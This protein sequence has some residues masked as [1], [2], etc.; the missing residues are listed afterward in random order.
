MVRSVQM[1]DLWLDQPEVVAR[2]GIWGMIVVR[3]RRIQGNEW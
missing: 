1:G 2:G 3:G